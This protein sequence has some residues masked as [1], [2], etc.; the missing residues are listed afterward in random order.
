MID[1]YPVLAVLGA[2]SQ[3]ETV[4]RG[5]EEL[6]VKESDRLSAIVAGLRASGVSVEELPDG[7]AIAGYGPDGVRGGCRIQTNMDHR[8]SMSFL[9]AG[10]ASREPI[11]VDDVS[12]VA[13]SFPGFRALMRGLGAEF[14]IPTS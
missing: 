8:I 6:R 4:L 11:V 5:L 1:E 10:L 13:T 12:M 3:G 7:L 9:V 14:S 2:F